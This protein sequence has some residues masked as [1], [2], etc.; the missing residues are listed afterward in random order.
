MDRVGPPLLQL[1][2]TQQLQPSLLELLE[3]LIV[4][5]KASSIANGSSD[6]IATADKNDG[7]DDDDDDDDVPDDDDDDDFHTT[8]VR[9]RNPYAYVYDDDVDVDDYYDGNYEGDD[10]AYTRLF[11]WS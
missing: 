10:A 3:Q 6:D 1:S 7:S 4:D 11:H 8:P 5:V 9:P 2:R